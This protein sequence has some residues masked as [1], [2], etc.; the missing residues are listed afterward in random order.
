[1]RFISSFLFT[2]KTTQSHSGESVRFAQRLLSGQRKEGG[3]KP[4]AF[5]AIDVRDVGLAHIHAM[6]RPAAAGK[7]F[8]LS[9]SVAMTQ[10]ELSNV[11]RGAGQE[12]WPYHDVMPTRF[13]SS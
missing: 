8:I 7:R 1:M 12:F 13:V 3:V 6:T 11:L 10:L 2:K 5:G 4:I 9:S